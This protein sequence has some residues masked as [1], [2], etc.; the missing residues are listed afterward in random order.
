M[1]VD[2]NPMNLN[3]A[4]FFAPGIQTSDEKIVPEILSHSL[5]KGKDDQSLT[6]LNQYKLL[7][8]RNKDEV[9]AGGSNTEFLRSSG[10]RISIENN[11]EGQI[12]RAVELINR[13]NQLNFTKWR[14]PEDQDAARAKLREEIARFDVQA[15]LVRV[16]DHYGDYGFCGFFA[17]RVFEGG[18]KTL[19]HY[20]F[21]CRILNMGVEAFIYQKVLNRPALTVKGDV[22]SN[23]ITADP[24][25]WIENVFSHDELTDRAK[26]GAPVS[27][28]G[29]CDLAILDH[30]FRVISAE[31]RGEYNISRNDI[32]LRLDHSLITRYAVN[33]IPPAAIDAARALGYVPEDFRSPVFSDPRSGCW[34]MSFLPD[35]LGSS[36]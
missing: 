30:Y 20:C 15:G 29:G 10:I 9:A 6:R 31:V 35:S 21:S 26:N 14:L 5:F 12:D 34:V 27:L 28:R 36:I 32:T 33:G 16:T 19:I 4:Q 7:E 22:L 1:M 13:T 2:D 3:E 25:D 24:V 18:L 11:I 17:T 23:P 8:K